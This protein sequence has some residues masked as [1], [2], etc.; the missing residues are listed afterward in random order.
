MTK[1]RHPAA[2]EQIAMI[3]S[4]SRVFA[5]AALLA[6]CAASAEEAPPPELA[7]LRSAFAAAVAARDIAAMA[8]VSRFPLTNQVY[9]SPD[10]VSRA[11][12]VG[13]VVVNGYWEHTECLRTAP[14]ERDVREE[15][16]LASW[17][18]ACDHGKNIF[19]FVRAGRRWAY[20]GFES[21]GE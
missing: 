20:G 9:G 15:K 3:R 4:V 21:A 1:G 6:C 11:E 10:K 7:K 18:V 14:L 12:F 8:T 19:H 13:S 5:T 2:K 17:F 16:A